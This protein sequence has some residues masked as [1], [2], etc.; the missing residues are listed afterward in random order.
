MTYPDGEVVNGSWDIRG[1]F[2]EYIGNYPVKDKTI[3]DVGTASGFLAFN[4]EAAGGIV[5]ALE[6]A[7]TAEF[8]RLPIK[9]M[10]YFS[11]RREWQKFYNE[12]HLIPLKN[13]WWYGFH[14]FGSS[15]K[16]MYSPIEDLYDWDDQFDVVIAGAIIEHI[17][18]PVT[19]IG[20]MARVAREAL[21][22]A[23][24]E[25]LATDD[26]LMA[27]AVGMDPVHDYMWWVLSRGLYRKIFA[28]VGFDVEFVTARATH[29]TVEYTRPTIIAKRWATT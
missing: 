29:N 10:E 2:N 4:A 18:D 26:L 12:I 20:A 27:P 28:N 8:K 6:A 22:I 19:F 7:S 25:V 21:I 14:K 9:D 3:L 16:L 11:R 5:T 13:S 17:S 24:T 15:C 23:F 1:K